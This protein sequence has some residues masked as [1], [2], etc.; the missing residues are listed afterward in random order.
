MKCVWWKLF[1]I[2]HGMECVTLG[3]SCYI[4]TQ[5]KEMAGH[6]KTNG[7]ES[8]SFEF[9]REGGDTRISRLMSMDMEMAL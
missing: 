1:I 3:S 8:I 6:I 7:F 2:A 5:E 9:G 4:E